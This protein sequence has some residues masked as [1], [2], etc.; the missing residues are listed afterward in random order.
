MRF[1]GYLSP[2]S[3]D[4]GQGCHGTIDDLAD[5]VAI[6]GVDRVIIA[7]PEISDALVMTISER[8]AARRIP[9][10]VVPSTI[11]LQL[12]RDAMSA[13]PGV[14][15][16]P[17]ESPLLSVGDLIVKRFL[18]VT[19]GVTTLVMLSPVMLVITIA[20]KLESGGPATWKTYRPGKGGRVFGMRKYRTTV[21]VPDP[22]E[23]RSGT[24]HD[25]EV[26]TRVGRILRRLALDEIPQL[27][28]VLY[29]EMSLVG[30]RPVPI[31]DFR[32]LDDWHKKR[33]LV[34]PGITGLWQLSGRQTRL[35]D[36]ELLI[37]YDHLARLDLR[38]AHHW[39]LWHDLTILAKTPFVVLRQKTN[40]P[41]SAR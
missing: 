33:Y 5:A 23:E 12:H 25:G 27:V 39:T 15:L 24:E 32:R 26:V 11:D 40:L 17:I 1:V 37:D 4:H 18:D 13:G 2:D 35:V 31:A 10:E 29:G 38:Y 21:A 6:V 7:D 20:I 28:N 14:L 36:G 22:Y 19:V 16:R 8:C 9:V 34:P 41:T 30:P 3:G